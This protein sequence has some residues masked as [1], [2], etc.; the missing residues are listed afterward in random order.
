MAKRIITVLG[1]T[2]KQGGSVVKSILEDS[3]AS[4][5]FHVRAV[6]RDP[7][8]EGAKSLASLGAEVIAGDLND[9][10]SLHAAIK[11]AYGVFSV[12]NFW[13]LFSAEAEEKQG[14]A[15]ADVCKVY[16]AVTAMGVELRAVLTRV[17]A[18]GVKHLVWSSLLNV[19]KLSHGVLPNVHH[20]DAKANVEEYIRS[21]G[22][23]ASFF[24]PGFYM[25]NLP[26][27]SLRD[28]GNGKWALALPMPADSP[29]PLFDTEADTGKFVKAMF[30]NEQKVLGKR[31][32]GATAYYTPTEILD[33]FK[34]L[35]PQTGKDTVFSQLPGH[36]FKGILAST[37]AP[38]PIQEEMLQNMRLMPEFG[39]YGGD[40]LDSS[41]AVR[42]YPSTCFGFSP[43]ETPKILSEK[44]TTWKEYAKNNE[45][46]AGLN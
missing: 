42:N 2:G 19:N 12:T 26:K 17:Q 25:S 28:M 39:Y 29:M 13:E 46:F 14:R 5:Q 36:V 15:V 6:T 30:L 11:G 3:N 41:L 45:A 37:G 8:K 22:L 7:A 18:E 35:F 10:D 40:T 24:L 43:T 23:P 31:I 32:Y 20:F 9:K 27:K 21:L 38:E 33:Q 34:E 16:R 1:S 4:S 44:P